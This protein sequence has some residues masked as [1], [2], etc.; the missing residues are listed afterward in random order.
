MT[1]VSL[2]DHRALAAFRYELR[3][4]LAFSERA[5]R[6]ADIE[7]QQ[8]QLLLAVRGLPADREPTIGAVAERLCLEHHT[9]VALVDKLEARGFVRRERASDDRRKVLVVLEPPGVEKL[10]ALS[11]LHKA[12]LA[13]AGEPMLEA[14]RAILGDLVSAGARAGA[15]GPSPRA[16]APRKHPGAVRAPT[17]TVARR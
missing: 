17:R 14:L 5:A 3:R 11:R 9:T 4:F 1:R 6:S 15:S 2:A 12:H 13:T 16:R 10:E 8:H 7:P